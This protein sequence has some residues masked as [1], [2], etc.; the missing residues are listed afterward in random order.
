MKQVDF[1]KGSVSKNIFMQAL[2][3]FVA[4]I[5]NLL[6]NIVD[7]IY[8]A[9]IKDVGTE[10]LAAVGLV[11]PVIVIVLAFSL[12]FGSGGSPLFAIERGRE[13]KHRA[14]LIMDLS[15]SMIICASIIITILTLVF[16]K[17]ILIFS[18]SDKEELKYALPY[19]RIYIFG[20][21]FSMI[22]S[23]MNPFINAEGFPIAGMIS[24][25]AGAF[26]NI[27][28]DPIFI[29]ALKMGVSGAAIATIISQAISATWI[30]YFLIKKADIKLKILSPRRAFKHGREMKN[31]IGLG[32]ASFIMQVTNSFVQIAANNVLTRTGG[33]VYVSV[34]T[35]VN[36]ARQVLETP[37]IAI[38]EG[39][40]PVIS[41]NYGARN[42]ERIKKSI[43]VMALMGFTYVLI[44][45][46]MVMAAPHWI[47][48]I[49]T[50]DKDLIEKSIGAF[51]IYFSAFI[52]MCFQYTGQS[53]FKSLNKKKQAI[54][55][56][57]LRKAILVIPL[58]FILPHFVNPSQNGVFMAEPI[59]NILGGTTC[60]IVMLCNVIP[61]I[62]Q[63]KK[64]SDRSY[65]K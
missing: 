62:K 41:F 45:W 44:A 19:L 60:F 3:M 36:S 43:I 22:A 10:A 61:E 33:A 46:I 35:I 29:F 24:N 59:S 5:I 52:F 37:C 8:I 16:S 7:R 47:I 4:Q 13:K 58:T 32:T 53:V 18:G 21:I 12:L 11:F 50:P 57:L 6:Y 23:G 39:A 65:I 64:E 15:F 26:S 25:I 20:T 34:M 27:I 55:F 30:L 17:E 28:L 48:S 56:S 9:R 51:R 54:F 42:A 63:M 31:I 1:S 14:G 2:P 40:S 49:F 38:T